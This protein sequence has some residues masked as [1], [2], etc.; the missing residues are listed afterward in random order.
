VGTVEILVRPGEMAEGQ[1]IH[2][3]KVVNDRFMTP[4]HL[5]ARRAKV[6]MQLRL[7]GL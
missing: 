7:G 3:M 4:K 5:A 2:G 1:L 6:Q